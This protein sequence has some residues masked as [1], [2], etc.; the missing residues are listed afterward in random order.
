MSTTRTNVPPS[1][2]PAD[3]MAELE[4]AIDDAV[5]GVRRPETIDDACREMDVG[6]EEV[7]QRLGETNLAET[8][9][10]PDDE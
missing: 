8:L 9:T 10:D 1:A 5:K 3:L 6:R 2:I 7:R 4:Q